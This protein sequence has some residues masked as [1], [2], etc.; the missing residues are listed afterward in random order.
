ML[1]RGAPRGVPRLFTAHKHRRHTRDQNSRRARR[2]SLRPDHMLALTNCQQY[3]ALWPHLQIVAAGQ[4]WARSANPPIR[5]RYADS[6][7]LI[8]QT[9]EM[10]A[11]SKPMPSNKLVQFQMHQI[12]GLFRPGWARQPDDHRKAGRLPVVA[13]NGAPTGFNAG[14]HECEAKSNSSRGTIA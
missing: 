4:S 10:S 11:C 9:S 12:L 1:D 3:T 2:K 5:Q 13:C 6:S 14:F 7:G 8:F